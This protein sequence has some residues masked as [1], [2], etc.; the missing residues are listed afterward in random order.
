MTDDKAN[1]DEDGERRREH[2]RMMAMDDVSIGTVWGRYR[3]G[4]GSV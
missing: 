1:V 4:I 2:E 3:V